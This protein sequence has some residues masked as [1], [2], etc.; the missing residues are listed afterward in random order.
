MYQTRF[1]ISLT[2]AVFLFACTKDSTPTPPPVP[3]PK[4][5][6]PEANKLA[7]DNQLQYVEIKDGVIRGFNQSHFFE[8]SNDFKTF[9]T[10][11][12]ATSPQYI[13]C[14][15]VA[16]DKVAMTVGS[17]IPGNLLYS[18]DFGKTH[19][20]IKL[21]IPT[22]HFTPGMA[23]GNDDLHWIDDNTLLLVK[24]KA[25]PEDRKIYTNPE[26]SI[27]KIDLLSQ[28]SQLLSTISNYRGGSLT[29]SSPSRGWM[30]LHKEFFID[31]VKFN[32]STNLT[33]TSDG[34]KTWSVPVLI[35][36]F[37]PYSL[38]KRSG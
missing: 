32:Q 34:G 2:F 35:D 14:I 19:K 29:F 33:T 6:Y 11:P 10:Q 12:F 3:V 24:T 23:Y 7:K 37:I 21:P 15:T 5:E 38:K 27:W 16:G 8:T 20:I 1:L 9:T 30:L 26:T 4:V 25:I 31:T 17:T 36:S 18:H 28:S 13:K 22:S